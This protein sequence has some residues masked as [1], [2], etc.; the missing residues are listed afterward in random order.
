MPVTEVQIEQANSQFWGQMVG[1]EMQRVAPSAWLD[2]IQ[3]TGRCHLSGAWTGRVEVRMTHGLAKMATCAMLAV[4]EDSVQR[5]DMIDA[6]KEIANMIA[7][8][9]KSTLPRPCAMTVPEAAVETKATY[10]EEP[11]TCSAE[12]LHQQGRL[13]V[14]MVESLGS[15]NSSHR[16]TRP[17]VEEAL[18]A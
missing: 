2:A 14:R 11:A 8:T 12:F 18:T 7:G 16:N 3:V 6:V 4:P 17:Q 1:V 10:Q 15:Q 9:L 13:I 5:E